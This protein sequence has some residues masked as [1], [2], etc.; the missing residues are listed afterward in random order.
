MACYII[1]PCRYAST[2]LPG[3]P[4]IPVEGRPLVQWVYEGVKGSTL[5]DDI[6]IAT[7]DERIVHVCSGFGA[8]VL[9]TR[10]DHPSGTDRVEEA[11]SKL[12]CKERDI[13]IN[14]QGDEPLVNGEIVDLLVRTLLE[15][16]GIPMATLAF[17]STSIEDYNNPDVVK[18]VFNRKGQALYFSRAPIPFD[19]DGVTEDFFFW[20]HQGFYAYRYGFLKEFVSWRPSEL[21]H[22]ERLEQVRALEYGAPILVVPSPKDTIGVDRP[23]DIER[24]RPHLTIS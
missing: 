17:P 3:K 22:R 6:F 15:N 4:L 7:D 23:E 13:L 11:A 9:M 18:V 8:K 20:K 16:P 2:R 21:E 1:I 24:V 10:K 14:I 5:V 19:R 12:G